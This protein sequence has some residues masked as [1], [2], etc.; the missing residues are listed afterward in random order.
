MNGGGIAGGERERKALLR[1]AADGV[2]GY[3][4][5]LDE[6]TG[7]FAVSAALFVCVMLFAGAAVFFSLMRGPEQVLVPDVTG[8]ELAAALIEMQEKE[9]YP[10]L[11]L[12][13][14]D[15]PGDKGLVMEQSPEAGAVVKAGRRIALT[16]SL[17]VVVETV[18]NFVGQDYNSAHIR[19]QALFSGAAKPLIVFAPPLYQA[20]SAPPGTI[21]AQEPPAGTHIAGPV[22]VRLAVS[23]GLDGG[24]ARI[25]DL[26]GLTIAETLA[27][28]P[29]ANIIFDFT[30][31]P[32]GDGDTPGTVVR[33]ERAGETAPE[34][35]RAEAEFALGDAAAGQTEGIFYARLPDY[36]YPLAVRLD[37][38]TPAG[39]AYTIITLNHPGGDFS[40]P[41]AVPEG[42]ELA[43]YAA[44]REAARRAAE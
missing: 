17:G 24:T 14:S 25:P 6:S 30:S 40:V 41:Y 44:G 12:R 15:T 16:V 22:T 5:R 9:L 31:R 19:L 39:D 20:S 21:L 11:T 23:R 29:G 18:E 37:A 42:S 26:R 4:R 32:A 33:Q 35:S 13:F 3:F 27:R 28:L 10:R 34:W 43:L 38:F 36:P 1:R 2:R 7:A 8:M